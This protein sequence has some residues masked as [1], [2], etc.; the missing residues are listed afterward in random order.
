MKLA[1]VRADGTGNPNTRDGRPK[2]CRW[3]GM[4]W[5]LPA[6][7]DRPVTPFAPFVA[8]N[9]SRLEKKARYRIAPFARDQGIEVDGIVAEMTVHPV[10]P[11]V[12][13]MR[14]DLP[15]R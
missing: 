13:L 2:G 1:V 4:L 8:E 3:E 10:G 15:L 5:I 11:H 7:A 12:N 9:E 14:I 6:G